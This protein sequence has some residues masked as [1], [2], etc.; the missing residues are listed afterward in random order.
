MGPAALS[1][2]L[3]V[4]SAFMICQVFK[5][6]SRPPLHAPSKAMSPVETIHP[7]NWFARLA[8]T[9]GPNF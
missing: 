1:P 8:L 5:E 7:R 6:A 3:I 9:G 4:F 2:Q